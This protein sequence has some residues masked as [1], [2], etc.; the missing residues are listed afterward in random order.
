MPAGIVTAAKASA[1]QAGARVLAGGGNAA[2]AAV[3]S[4][5]A[6]TVAD[7]ANCGI[8]GYGGYALID[9]GDTSCPLQVEFN[10]AAPAAL[11]AGMLEQA[12]YRD[13]FI[14][15]GMSVSRPSVVAGLKR[16]HDRFG[17]PGCSLQLSPALETEGGPL[18]EMQ[19]TSRGPPWRC[20][21][22]GRCASQRPGR[23]SRRLRQFSTPHICAPPTR[24]E[25][26]YP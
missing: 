25:F 16:I 13:S 15:G 24:T 6:L 9:R 26:S 12:P 11:E 4:A 19:P 21:R 17:A 14:Y 23:S 2:D 20:A 5:F 7:P 10:T 3:A 18:F 22:V 1:A 8:G